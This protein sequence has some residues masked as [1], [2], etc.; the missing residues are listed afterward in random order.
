M[1]LDRMIANVVVG[2]ESFN[3]DGG[4]WLKRFLESLGCDDGGFAGT[5]AANASDIYYTPF[6]VMALSALGVSLDL[7]RLAR[8]ADSVF[9][10]D[11]LD[12]AHLA[13]LAR[14]EALL[15]I[16]SG[17]GDSVESLPDRIPRRRE[18]IAEIL[19]YRASDGGFSHFAKLAD[20]STPYGVFLA[21]NALAEL[22]APECDS[23][24][25]AECVMRFQL[26]DGS[27]SN[28]RGDAFGGVNATAAAVAVL[29]ESGGLRGADV[30]STIKYIR[31][32]SCA[33]GFKASARAP[34]PD[35][36]STATALVALNLL[37]VD[38]T[39]DEQSSYLE[40]IQDHWR[41]VSDT[42]GGFAG[43]IIAEVPDAEYTFYAIMAL[44]MLSRPI[45]NRK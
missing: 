38:L 5:I 6:A 2:V 15:V 24:I 44:G 39:Q 14:L 29:A 7:D 19:E 23:A 13:S 8:F 30:D 1:I 43:D 11:S 26:H 34:L 41:D 31:S 45:L 9:E 25:L 20:E 42:A 4:E 37:G 28:S 17:D 32:M 18:L 35:L 27:F 33:G 36:L 21:S 10:F 3:S 22:F 12:L 40:F 16:S